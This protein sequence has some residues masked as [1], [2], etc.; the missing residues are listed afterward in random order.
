MLFVLFGNILCGSDLAF[1]YKTIRSVSEPHLYITLRDG[2][3]RLKES[4][5]PMTGLE[6]NIIKFEGLGDGLRIVVNGK[7]ICRA[8]PDNNMVVTCEIATEKNTEWTVVK[9]SS[10]EIIETDGF[11]LV[12]DERDSRLETGG[13]RLSVEKCTETSNYV[14]KISDIDPLIYNG[15]LGENI[16]SVS[17][18]TPYI[19]L[20]GDNSA[21][22]GNISVN[23]Q[24]YELKQLSETVFGNF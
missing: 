5:P 17:T 11:C 12:K 4:R 21:R 24:S 15:N 2:I 6:S 18:P 10:G 7:A 9:K 8:G 19:N 3:V 22:K 23:P 16:H 13:Y 1:G 20:V 14:W